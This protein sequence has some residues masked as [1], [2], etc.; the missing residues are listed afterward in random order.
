VRIEGVALED[1]RDVAILGGDIVD[2][3]LADD[4]DEAFLIL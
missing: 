3:P 4:R 1:H 2:D